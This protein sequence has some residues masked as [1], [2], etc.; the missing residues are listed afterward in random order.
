MYFRFLQ[1]SWPLELLPLH[2]TKKNLIETNCSAYSS[3]PRIKVVA[4]VFLLKLSIIS[5]DF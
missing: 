1:N 4:R 3:W 2:K 5:H